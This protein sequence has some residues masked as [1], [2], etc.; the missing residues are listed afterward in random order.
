M[1]W[2]GPVHVWGTR[3]MHVASR[4]FTPPPPPIFS[5]KRGGK[6]KKKVKKKKKKKKIKYLPLD[7]NS[8]TAA[9]VD[10]AAVTGSQYMV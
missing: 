5:S 10:P 2:A 7:Q 1:S 8:P 9:E 6:K 3:E 4:C